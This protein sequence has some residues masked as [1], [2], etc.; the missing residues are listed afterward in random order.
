MIRFNISIYNTHPNSIYFYQLI[1]LLQSIK[2]LYHNSAEIGLAYTQ[3][4]D[5]AIRKL[6]KKFRNIKIL[7]FKNKTRINKN[8]DYLLPAAPKKLN[9]WYELLC[10]S[11]YR[12]Q[13]FMDTDMIILKKIDKFFKYPF[14]I[15]FTYKT[16]KKEDWWKPINT[17]LILVKSSYKTKNFMKKWRD[18]TNKILNSYKLFD[19]KWGAADQQSFG[20]L[21]ENNY[22]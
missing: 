12:F 5:D 1:A 13:V 16:E 4:S 18:E 8:T 9:M 2:N 17:G 7:K 21:I 15:G 6:K 20:E 11:N 22:E 3:L 14:D 10:A 19:H